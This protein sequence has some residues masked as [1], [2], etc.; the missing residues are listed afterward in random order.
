MGRG[1]A[2]VLARGRTRRGRLRAT[3]TGTGGRRPTIRPA[4]KAPEVR[5]AGGPDGPAARLRGHRRRPGRRGR[6]L[7]GPRA[8]R[9]G[10]D[11]RPRAVRRVL[12]VLGLH[13][14][15]RP[16]STRPRSMPAA[17]T[18]TGSAPRTRRDYMISR[19]GTDFPSDAGH[20]ERAR[21]GRRGR[22]PGR[23][24]DRRPGAGRGHA[25]RRRSTCCAP[26]TSSSPSARSSTVPGH[27][28]PRHDHAL[29]E[30]RGHEH[31]RAAR[32]ASWSSAP[33]RPASRWP[34]SSP[35]TGCPTTLVASRAAGQPEGPPAQ[36][37]GRSR[38]RS[39]ATASTSGPASARCA[40]GRAR[41]PRVP[42]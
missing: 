20:V 35:A 42:T 11:H 6:G 24:P 8:R 32:A 40:C 10:R 30:P 4:P 39:A 17:A 18:T 1:R 19:E 41:A 28:G 16:C 26:G 25:R 3:A 36:L 9:L 34:R 33:A 27:R 23:R 7:P 22:H 29:D 38:R 31:A 14:L 21:G 37:G 13:A 15:A 12:P 2:R 5:H